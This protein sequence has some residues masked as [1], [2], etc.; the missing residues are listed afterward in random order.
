MEHPLIR[1][2]RKAILPPG[3]PPRNTDLL[4]I[5]YASLHHKPRSPAE[6]QAFGHALKVM[7]GLYAS[8]LGSCVMQ[9]HL[10]P[11]PPPGARRRAA[12]A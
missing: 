1:C 2:L 9:H 3:Q 7:A 11:P 5:G 8:P 10:M 6:G 4:S 12:D